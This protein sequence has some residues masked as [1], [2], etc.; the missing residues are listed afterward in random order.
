MADII[1]LAQARVEELRADAL[2]ARERSAAGRKPLPW[3]R[4]C[5]GCGDPIPLAR[6]EAKPDAGNCVECQTLA[7]RPRR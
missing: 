5:T 7:E 4:D 3:P 2:A 1:D 6:A